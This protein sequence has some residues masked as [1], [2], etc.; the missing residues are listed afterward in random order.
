MNKAGFLAGACVLAGLVQAAAGQSHVETFT[1]G[2]NHGAWTIGNGFDTL[3]SAGGNPGWYLHNPNIDTFAPQPRTG[4]GVASAYTGDYRARDVRSLGIDL[5][6]HSTQ[7]NFARPLALMLGNDA[8]T[9]F[10]FNDDCFVYVVSSQLVPQ[11]AEGWKRFEIAVPAQSATMPAGWT[12]QGACSASPDV[13]WNNVIT[14]VTSVRWFYGDPANFFIFDIWNIG[15]DNVRI[16]EALG[17]AFCSGDGSAGPC[18][19][20]NAGG[21]G[22]G[23]ANST[24]AGALLQ[25]SG[26]ASV[27]ADDLVF[28]GLQLR[29]NALSILVQGSLV[30]APVPFGDGLR[31]VGGTLKRLDVAAADAG[32]GVTFGPGLAATGGWTGGSTF[33]FQAYYRDPFGPCGANFNVSSALSIVFQ[34]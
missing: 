5:I 19:C 21:R 7:F 15:I 22:E 24:G 12:T 26:S 14:N 30:I 31:C 9:P 28:H 2:T 6:T 25:A 33:A 20:A 13:A 4:A 27:A 16:D 29:P 10:N 3:E 32:G 11:V 23:C 8:G 18:P 34:P 17:D 1:G